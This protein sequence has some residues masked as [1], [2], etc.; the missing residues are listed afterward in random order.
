MNKAQV[1]RILKRLFDFRPVR[2]VTINVTALPQNQLL[3]SRCAIVTG[4]TSGI[5]Y[6][7]A[8]A[9]LKAGAS[10]IITGRTKSRL[11]ATI[12]KLKK[13]KKQNCTFRLQRSRKNRKKMPEK[14]LPVSAFMSDGILW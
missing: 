9:F 3:K 10:V 13:S 5:G 11:D 2:N 7:I 12:E 14:H 8:E 1:K 4:G 6:A